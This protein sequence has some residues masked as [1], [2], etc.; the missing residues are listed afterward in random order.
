MVRVWEFVGHGLKIMT[1][2]QYTQFHL[3][4]TF[5]A[6]VW[7]TTPDSDTNVTSFEAEHGMP[8]RTISQSLTESS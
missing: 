4:L 2:E 8:M 3:N 1:V 5:L 6:H 7:N